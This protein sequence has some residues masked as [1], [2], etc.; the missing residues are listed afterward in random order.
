M[1]M[2]PTEPALIVAVPEAERA[3][4]RFRAALDLAAGWGVPAHV[5][6]LYPFL[7][8]QRI[9]EDVLTTLSQNFE[10]TPRVRCLVRARRLVR[11]YRDVARSAA[12]R[13]VPPAHLSG[14]AAVPGGAAICPRPYRRRTASDHWS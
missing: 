6:V 9:N 12:G 4:A 13:R 8:P 11:R 5:T 1:A 14:V 2:E 3:V 7:P 10:A